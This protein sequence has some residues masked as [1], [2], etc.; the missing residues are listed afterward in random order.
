MS[1][2]GLPVPPHPRGQDHSCLSL[3]E[4]ESS[5]EGQ[6]AR[7]VTSAAGGAAGHEVLRVPLVLGLPA[8][9]AVGGALPKAAEKRSQADAP[10]DRARTLSRPARPG[11][12]PPQHHPP[13]QRGGLATV[14]LRRLKPLALALRPP[15]P[16]PPP[17]RSA[18]L[19]PLPARMAGEGRPLPPASGRM[20]KSE[21]CSDL[22]LFFYPPSPHSSKEGQWAHRLASTW[23]TLAWPWSAALR[24]AA[25]CR[26]ATRL[27]RRLSSTL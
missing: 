10:G 27:V 20:G 1:P 26:A 23:R 25:R 3:A 12:G 7:K 13:G 16:T 21:S 2:E 19:L 9:Q 15:L 6:S 11:P 8:A 5:R 17:R 4:G 14:T 24:L 18:L 22:W